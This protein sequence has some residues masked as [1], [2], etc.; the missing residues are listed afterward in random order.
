MNDNS[1][2]PEG[3]VRPE[4]PDAELLASICDGKTEVFW[5][6]WNRHQTGLRR[7]CLRKMDGNVADAE[8]ALSQVMIKALDRLP[9][10]AGKII[11]LEAWLHG[12]AKNLCIDLRRERHRR[13]EIAESWKITTLAEPKTSQSLLRFEV[14]SEI[15]QRITAL[16]PPLRE[17]F[18]LHIVRD[19]PV[20]EVAT[21][22]GLS[23]AN[24]RKRVQLARARLRRNIESSRDDSGVGPGDKPSPPAVPAKPP[25]HQSQPRE[26]FSSALVIR[27]ACVKL[28]CGVEQL[29]H[30][31][32]TTAP[33]SPGRKMKSLLSYTRQHPDHWDKHLELAEL[34]HMIGDW[35]KAVVE[36]QHVLAGRPH[37][38]AT[39]KLGDALLKL[40]RPESAA[41]VFRDARRQD[42]Q[43]A[44]IRR[45]LDG[46][47]AFCERNT[48]RSVMEFQ[49]AM[50]LEPGGPC[51]RHGLALAH[52]LAGNLT[53]ALAAIRRVLDLNPNDLVALSLG[54]EM[55]LAAGHPEEAVRRAQQ[56]LKLAPDD[57]LTM[58]RLID[59]RCQLGLT[60]GTAGLE[61]KRLL[62]RTLGL[63]PDSFLMRE[64][65]AAFSLAQGE[66]QRALAVHREF[67]EQHPQCPRGQQI[68]SQLLA[69]TGLLVRLPAE[70]RVWKWS[71]AKRCN[72]ACHWHEKAEPI[73]A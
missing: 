54:H 22:L 5:R 51:H 58:R 23:S 11:S 42:F 49:A 59:C 24:V 38:P 14:E 52:R 53:E 66:P 31:F 55:L 67:V 43:S 39:L 9:A 45:H 61:T 56:L 29:L 62:R 2:Q 20:K 8:D 4:P 44:V 12:L 10:S 69:A 48:D 68:Y 60:Q 7:L 40:G 71:T 34:F 65:L 72:G 1:M 3:K 37:L 13:S 33:V 36:W 28:P 47:I 26:L 16:P 6:L 18:V 73:R 17:S 27:T 41:D 70:P 32:P 15:Q 21:Q 50:D 19:I 57:L 30:V 35:N 25:R 64:S 63:S 46:W